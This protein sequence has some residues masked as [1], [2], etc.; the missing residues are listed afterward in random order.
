MNH[1]LPLIEKKLEELLTPPPSS[2]EKLFEAARY[3][4]LSAGKRL[5]PLLL[6]ATAEAFSVPIDLAI[7]PAC[8]LELVHTYSL[9]HDDLPCMDNDDFRRGKP[10]LHKKYDEATAVLTGDFLLTYAFEVL[11]KSPGLTAE[12]KVQMI[13]VLSSRSGGNGM[14][15]GQLLD[16]EVGSHN[17]E[18]LNYIHRKKT[19]DLLIASLELGGIIAGLSPSLMD[20][21]QIFGEEIGL[22]FQITDDLIDLSSEKEGK[23]TYVSCLGMENAKKTASDLL[24]QAL[25]RLTQC[26][27]PQPLHT[28][29]EALVLRSK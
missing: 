27:N 22:A 26:P 10:T 16:M 8:A 20:E 24:E 11:A 25:K 19:A 12:Q 6:L 14:V 15:A 1:Y 9:I 18:R 21:I 2:Q 23:I 29:A 4:T 17:L 28:M 3:M 5:R 13:Q 7:T